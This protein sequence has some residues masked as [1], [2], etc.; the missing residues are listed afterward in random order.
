M[1]TFCPCQRKQIELCIKTKR[2]RA[3]GREILKIKESQEKRSRK[4]CQSKTFEKMWMRWENEQAG[5]WT[6]VYGVMYNMCVLY[7]SVREKWVLRS[8]IALDMTDPRTIQVKLA[9][10]SSMTSAVVAAT[11]SASASMMASCLSHSAWLCILNAPS[12]HPFSWLAMFDCGR[13]PPLIESKRDARP[14]PYTHSARAQRLV[15][16]MKIC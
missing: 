9:F 15:A 5:R 16:K 6:S 8:Q 7:E 2:E 14:F 4:K 3:G 11:A 13:G 1:N 12:F 10:L